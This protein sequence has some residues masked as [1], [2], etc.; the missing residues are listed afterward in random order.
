MESKV[1]VKG[2]GLRELFRV[3]T[4]S[5]GPQKDPEQS[6]TNK[7]WEKVWARIDKKGR[8]LTNGGTQNKKAKGK[9]SFKGNVETI[10]NVSPEK[11]EKISNKLESKSKDGKEIVD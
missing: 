11:K 7:V 1:N 3:Y 8:D 4:E 5:D 9:S 2:V 10:K 6:E